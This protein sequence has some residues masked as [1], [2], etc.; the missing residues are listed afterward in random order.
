MANA[1]LYYVCLFEKGTT[2]LEGNEWMNNE[3]IGVLHNVSIG[4]FV[5]YTDWLFGK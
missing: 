2:V 4:D 1:Q 3:W 5:Q